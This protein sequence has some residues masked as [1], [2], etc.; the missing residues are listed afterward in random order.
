MLSMLTGCTPLPDA[1]PVE[2]GIEYARRT[3]SGK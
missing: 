1:N 3:R 2:I